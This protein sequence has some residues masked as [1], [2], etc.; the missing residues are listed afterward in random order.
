MAAEVTADTHLWEVEHAYRTE[1]SVDESR[2]F[3]SWAEFLQEFG[4]ADDDYNLVFRWTWLEGADHELGDFN[5][6]PYYRHAILRVY[7]VAQRK[8]FWWS[9]DVK[10]CRADEPAIIDYLRP[11]MHYLM[12]LWSPLIRFLPEGVPS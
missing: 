9:R 1:N 5:G 7:F 8:D 2:T 12:S 3:E 6:D 4:D 11:R 10:V